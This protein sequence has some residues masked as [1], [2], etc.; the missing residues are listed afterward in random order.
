M[1]FFD[2]SEEQLQ[3]VEHIFNSVDYHLN[4]DHREGFIFDFTDYRKVVAYRKKNI[5]RIFLAYE[6]DEVIGYMS[7]F[8]SLD[9]DPANYPFG[10]L[11]SHLRHEWPFI[12]DLSK[13]GH[14]SF[15]N[16]MAVKRASAGER[17]TTSAPACWRLLSNTT[18]KA[19]KTG[20][21][22]CRCRA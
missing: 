8:D 18:T 6:G 5:G 2:V 10:F 14:F 17:T 16:Q 19:A 22:S 13:V 15:V 1:S 9:L 3:Q 20:R 11:Q 7:C 4:R 12:R 21:R